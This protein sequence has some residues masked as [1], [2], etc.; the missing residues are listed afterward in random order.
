MRVRRQPLPQVLA[1]IALLAFG[2]GSASPAAA[3][4]EAQSLQRLID[5]LTHALGLHAH[6]RARLVPANALLVSVE[7]MSDR[8]QFDLSFQ[9]SFLAGLTDEDVRTIVAHE[10][11]HVWIFTHHPY[12]QTE[13]LA[14][15]IALRVVTRE[16]LARVYDKVW[17]V[18]GVK[19][20]LERFL[21]APR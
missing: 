5:E 11:G 15:D 9:Q 1:V 6:V 3:V 21:P 19:G 4:D 18:R 20:D 16:S 14:N 7:P 13:R 8:R 12:L 17:A 2:S 10:L